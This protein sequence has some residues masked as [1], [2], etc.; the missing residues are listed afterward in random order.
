MNK[1]LISLAIA[2]II[3]TGCIRVAHNSNNTKPH[4]KPQSK[5]ISLSNEGT[6]CAYKSSPKEVV[7]KYYPLSSSCVSSSTIDWKLA[8]FDT[9]IDGSNLKI[10]SY[11]LYKRNNSPI[12]TA[13][14]GGANIKVKKLIV[15]TAK[16][17]II[18]GDKKI[19]D[20]EKIKKVVC[21]KKTSRGIEKTKNIR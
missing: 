19:I 13:D 6:I 9:K 21:F 20:L 16:T 10:D 17:T 11:A 14:C 7:V 12:A 8:G 18:W 5:L 4:S 1:I 2:P 3:I 15:P